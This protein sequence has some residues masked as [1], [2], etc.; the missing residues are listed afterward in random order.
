[1]LTSII[2]ENNDSFLCFARMFIQV[3]HNKTIYKHVREIT[4]I[5][6][7]ETIYQRW[8]QLLFA[9]LFGDESLCPKSKPQFELAST[10]ILSLLLFQTQPTWVFALLVPPWLFMSIEPWLLLVSRLQWEDSSVSLSNSSSKWFDL[11]CNDQNQFQVNQH[12]RK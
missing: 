6:I 3:I 1:M 12:I 7:C 10:F 9:P 11:N 4:Q 2:K 5:K 8:E